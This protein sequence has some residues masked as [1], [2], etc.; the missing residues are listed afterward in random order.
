MQ[1]RMTD[2][3]LEIARVYARSRML[4]RMSK[5]MPERMSDIVRQNVR[6]YM[7]YILPD[8]LSETMSEYLSGYMLTHTPT[9]IEILQPKMIFHV[10]K[11]MGS[12]ATKK[13]EGLCLPPLQMFNSWIYGT[14]IY[15]DR[16]KRPQ[17]DITAIMASELGQLSQ[18]GRT[19]GIFRLV[20]CY[21]YINIYYNLYI[22][23]KHIFDLYTLYIY[24]YIY[25]YTHTYPYI[26]IYM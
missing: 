15:L 8:G 20:T 5:Y 13:A 25:I 12:K 23:I 6:I 10:A 17:C 4:D 21:I 7:P 26:Y 11:D 14:F 24:T 1:E 22:C 18:N 2:R 16:L 19:L 3:M 9:P